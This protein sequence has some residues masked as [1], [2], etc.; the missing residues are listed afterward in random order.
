M[1]WCG[2]NA[3]EAGSTFS[4]LPAATQPLGNVPTYVPLDQG[5]DCT[6]SSPQH[7]STVQSDALR[8]GQPVQTNCLAVSS[9]FQYQ[10]C[11]DTSANPPQ[12]KEYIGTT[13]WPLFILNPSG[14]S[15]VPGG[16][17]VGFAAKTVTANYSIALTDAGLAFNNSGA[18]GDIT[19]SLPAIG[20]NNGLTYCFNAIAA[21][22]L[23]ISPAGSNII[24]LGT[25]IGNVSGSLTT[26]VQNASICITANNAGQ[27]VA[28]DSPDGVWTLNGSSTVT[29]PTILSYTPLNP[30]NNLADVSNA[31]TALAN[32]FGLP[33]VVSNAALAAATR[34][35][36][37]GSLIRDTYGNGNGA[38]ASQWTS[39]IGTCAANSKVSDGGACQDGGDGNSFVAVYPA[40]GADVREW[41]V[42]ADGVTSADVALAAANAWASANNARLLLP[43]GQIAIT[44]AATIALYNSFWQCAGQQPAAEGYPAGTFGNQGTTFLL[45]STTVQPFTI[46]MSVTMADCNFYWPNQNGASTPPTSYPPLFTDDGVHNLGNVTLT[47]VHPLNA[48]DFIKQ[49]T[50]SV[51]YGAI[52]LDGVAGYV[53]H[54]WLA[55]SNVPETVIVRGLIADYNLAPNALKTGNQYP[56][57]WTQQNGSLLHVLDGG[58][59]PVAGIDIEGGSVFAYGYG[60][61]IDANGILSE[62]RVNGAIFDATPNI[63]SQAAGGCTDLDITGTYYSYDFFNGSHTDNATAFSI[64]TPSVGC[65]A[66]LAI[67][68]LWETGN[69]TVLFASGND[70]KDIDLSLAGQGPYGAS[71]T[72]GT[73]YFANIAA[74][75]ASVR[76][77]DSAINPNA[78]N[79]SHEGIKATAAA[80]LLV[81][82]NAFTGVY[83]PVDLASFSGFALVDGNNGTGANSVAVD[84][85]SASQVI[86]GSNSF[87]K[88]AGKISVACS[89][90]L[91]GA[92]CALDAS[93][94][95]S[96]GLVTITNSTAT[97]GNIALTA[98]DGVGNR[99]CTYSYRQITAW[100]SPAPLQAF[101]TDSRNY[102]VVEASGALTGASTYGIYYDCRESQ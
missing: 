62:S 100:P 12:L 32:L 1:L 15:I 28:L 92:T 39:Q 70:V 74:A 11:I 66:R 55:L 57:K 51:A 38:P 3:A 86:Y 80:Q 48:Y 17:P 33:H 95:P 5:T 54:D 79:A 52:Q 98:Q 40:S 75:N 23:T 84:D 20:T 97:S 85:T 50:N 90:G 29:M 43:P 21:H 4:G 44:G 41:G 83:L 10:Q 36:Y 18:T 26:N 78:N 69:G 101:V 102:G 6:N 93:S 31:T 96:R 63:V 89:G 45:T 13:W 77:H 7:C 82:G 67:R 35:Q 56:I 27:W 76:I 8:L 81:K 61:R 99:Y 73:Y 47:R 42:K 30:A 37:P 72:A 9:P 16:G 22:N 24:V 14:P 68:G 25:A 64:G 46:R 91:T 2:G 59:N 60:I 94:S 34:A 58:G 87:N 19:L 53:I 71:S 49:S 65:N 88:P